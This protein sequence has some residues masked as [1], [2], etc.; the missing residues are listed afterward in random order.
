[1][2]TNDSEECEKITQENTSTN[3]E[4]GVRT[5]TK[6]V[7][8]EDNFDEVDESLDLTWLA[9]IFPPVGL[10]LYFLRRKK[11]PKKAKKYLIA[12]VIGFVVDISGL[13]WWLV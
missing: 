1:M 11:N 3:P 2:T 8:D 4:K 5:E 6:S 10:V 9:F 7:I 13:V 12:T